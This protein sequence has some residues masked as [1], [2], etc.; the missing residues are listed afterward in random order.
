[1]ITHCHRVYKGLMES[2][3]TLHPTLLADTVEITRWEVC[4]VLLMNDANYPWLILVPA[5][6]GLS[7]LHELDG[8]GR[9][10]VMDEIT[11]ASNTLENT[12]DP[13]R[14]NVAALGNMVEQL[15]IHVIARFRDDPAWPAPVWGA[16]PK[17]EYD[18]DKLRSM[19]AKLKTLLEDPKT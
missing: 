8:A 18:P 7:G 2:M 4:R 14:I 1:M 12:Y 6:Q 15:H 17:N 3:F 11:R 19:T 10:K 5:R 13:E 16:V 9:S